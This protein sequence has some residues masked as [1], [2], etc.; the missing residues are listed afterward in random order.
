MNDTINL[1]G[2]IKVLLNNKV[3]L[4][5]KNLIVQVGKNF[6]A[7]AVINSSASPFNAMA[8]GTG[9]TAASTADTALQTEVARAAF[10]TGTVSTNVVSLSNTY[11]AGTGTGAITE[12]GIFNNATSG[13]TMLSHVV[14]SAINKGA[15]DTLTINWTITVG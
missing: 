8:I 7:S 10:T 12:A 14:F 5:K 3:V 4:E 15:A 13:G 11:V 6:L 9:T 2:E 1:V